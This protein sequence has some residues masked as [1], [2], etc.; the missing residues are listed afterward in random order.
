MGEKNEKEYAAIRIE[1]DIWVTLKVVAA[2]HE[3]SISDLANEIL[4]N[5][6][7]AYTAEVER[8]TRG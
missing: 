5:G 7:G 2:I 4:R 6:L 3:R 1:R 8:L